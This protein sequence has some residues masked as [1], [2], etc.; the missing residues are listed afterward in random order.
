LHYERLRV[1][2]C[3]GESFCFALVLL[4][5]WSSHISRGV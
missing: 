5:F 1:L 3:Y 2:L 4:L